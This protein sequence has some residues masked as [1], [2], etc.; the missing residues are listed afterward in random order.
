MII[1]AVRSF[2]QRHSTLGLRIVSVKFPGGN[3]PVI[4]E[5]QLKISSTF[6]KRPAKNRYLQP[7]GQLHLTKG[8]WR[9]LKRGPVNEI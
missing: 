1:D 8:Q 3:N 2:A 4:L 7:G 9:I 6:S 5:L